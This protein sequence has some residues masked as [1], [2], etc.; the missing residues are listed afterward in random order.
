MRS[1]AIEFYIDAQDFERL[2]LRLDREGLEAWLGRVMREAHNVLQREMRKGGRGRIYHRKKGWHRASA[3][4]D[5]PAVDSGRLLSQS[6]VYVSY[7]EGVIGTNVHYAKYLQFGTSK[8]AP[9]KLYREAIL[10]A[11]K[12]IH[13]PE[14]VVVWGGD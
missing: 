6:R 1:M 9:R 10:D 2:G 5:Y 12:R 14:N 4:G 13:G 8:M 3:P 7:P 11:I